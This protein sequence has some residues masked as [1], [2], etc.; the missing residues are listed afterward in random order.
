MSVANTRLSASDRDAIASEVQPC[1]GIDAGAPGVSKFSVLL[2]VITDASGV[3]R[4]AEVAPADEGKLSNPVFAAFAQRAVAAVKNY[5][6]AK[7]PLPSYMLGQP[8]NFV[9]RFT[10]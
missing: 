7:L 10:P 9:F 3:V 1:W 4:E 6:C 5:Q 8:Q 2:Q